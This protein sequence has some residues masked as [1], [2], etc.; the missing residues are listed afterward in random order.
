MDIKL[1]AILFIMNAASAEFLPQ[2]GWDRSVEGDC[3]GFHARQADRPNIVCIMLTNQLVELDREVSAVMVLKS[4]NGKVATVVSILTIFPFFP[5][6]Y[7]HEEY[8]AAG[9]S[10]YPG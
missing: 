7:S 8:G 5:G 9:L 4:G 6:L 1:L 10:G 2:L 3:P